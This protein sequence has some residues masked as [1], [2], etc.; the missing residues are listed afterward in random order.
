MDDCSIHLFFF[1]VCVCVFSHPTADYDFVYEQG[2]KILAVTK[3]HNIFFCCWRQPLG[4]GLTS[5]G[6]GYM[7]IVLT[8]QLLCL[9]LSPHTLCLDAPLPQLDGNRHWH[10]K[11]SL[12]LEGGNDTSPPVEPTFSPL[13]RNR[14]QNVTTTD[15]N[16][17]P[18]V[19]QDILSIGI[20]VGLFGAAVIGMSAWVIYR[21]SVL[22][23]QQEAAAG[24]DLDGCNAFSLPQQ[25]EDG[26]S[27]MAVSLRNVDA[28]S[29]EEQPVRVILEEALPAVAPRSSLGKKTLKTT[30]VKQSHRS[31]ESSDPPFSSLLHEHSDDEI[32]HSLLTPEQREQ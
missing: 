5:R 26:D 29:D 2:G 10:L 12:N 11:R 13:V 17:Q 21:F 3:A 1:L 15:S 7:D 6:G 32:F 16:F 22:E 24:S 25:G 8:A 9:L 14:T 18:P 19:G 20:V 23:K 31:N 30:N 27:E 28:G 4:M